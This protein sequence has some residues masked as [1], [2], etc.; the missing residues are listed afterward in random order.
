MVDADLNLIGLARRSDDLSFAP[1]L[2]DPAQCKA[3]GRTEQRQVDA[4][5]AFG[6]Q[7][8]PR[9]VGPGPIKIDDL[10]AGPVDFCV[11]ENTLQCAREL[12]EHLGLPA[13]PFPAGEALARKVP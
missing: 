9:L 3:T 12:F 4:A 10:L 5:A 2:R 6:L 11:R 8:D 7:R 1:E 13:D